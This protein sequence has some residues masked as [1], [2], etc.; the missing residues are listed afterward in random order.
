MA[1]RNWKNQIDGNE[2]Y[3]MRVFWVTDCKSSNK[4]LSFQLLQKTL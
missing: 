4:I 1:D 3:Y 2:N